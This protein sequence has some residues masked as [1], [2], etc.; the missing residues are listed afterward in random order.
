MSR[1]TCSVNSCTGSVRGRGWCQVHY[2]L[3]Y[4]TGD[5]LSKRRRPRGT[6]YERFEIWV[7]KHGPIKKLKLGRCWLW[8]GALDSRGYGR[9]KDDDG[10]SDM[11]HRWSYKHFVGPIPEDLVLDHLCVNPPCVNPRHLEPVTHHANILDRGV[12][13]AAHLN[14]LKT[15]CNNGHPLSGSNIYLTKNRWGVART[16]KICHNARVARYHAK[17]RGLA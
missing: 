14:S 2:M 9:L 8:Q 16:C 5:A 1:A 4:R 13:N 6:A 3:W 15:Y 11:A 17:M 12:T 7:D 10:W